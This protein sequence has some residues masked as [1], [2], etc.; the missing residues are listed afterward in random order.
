MYRVVCDVN[1]MENVT[2]DS[3]CG[4]ALLTMDAVQQV[5]DYQITH[6]GAKNVDIQF[7]A[8]D[9]WVLVS[10]HVEREKA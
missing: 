1:G 9:S 6:Q 10:H 8:H 2:F 5:A 7:N 3:S 4:R